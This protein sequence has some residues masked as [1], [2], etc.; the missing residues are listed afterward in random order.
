MSQQLRDYE[1]TQSKYKEL[2]AQRMADCV[3]RRREQREAAEE[4]LKVMD[5]LK[6]QKMR[7]ALDVAE[8]QL[9][10]KQRRVT[11]GLE[12]WE[13]G[14]RRCRRHQRLEER[15]ALMSHRWMGKLG[16]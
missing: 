13:Q 10:L 14:L 16:V 3:L 2:H 6:L 8:E 9:E 11:E 15:K 5:S 12:H 7:R 4:R 1:S